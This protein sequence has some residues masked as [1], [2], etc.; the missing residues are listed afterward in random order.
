MSALLRLGA[1]FEES[2]YTLTIDEAADHFAT[3]GNKV[4]VARAW[5]SHARAN[6]SAAHHRNLSIFVTYTI[7]VVYQPPFIVSIF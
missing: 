2:A 6:I 7:Y 1:P 5:R 3:A 4:S